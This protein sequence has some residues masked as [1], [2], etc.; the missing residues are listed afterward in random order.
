MPELTL[1]KFRTQTSPAP[2]PVGRKYGLWPIGED[3]IMSTPTFE[4]VVHVLSHGTAADREELSAV[5]QRMYQSPF[6]GVLA[7]PETP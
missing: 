3:V 2:P 7:A 4:V 6:A 5:L 1:L